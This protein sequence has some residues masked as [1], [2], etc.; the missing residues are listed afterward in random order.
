MV[1]LMTWAQHIV[2]FQGDAASHIAGVSPVFKAHLFMG[3]TLFVIFPFTRLVHVWS[4]LPRWATW[5]EPGS[6]C[7]RAEP[8]PGTRRSRTCL[9]SSM[10]SN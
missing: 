9:S 4:G 5:A 1:S 10:A 7:V 8:R 6:W 2:T 3:L